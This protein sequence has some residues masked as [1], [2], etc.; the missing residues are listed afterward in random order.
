M[1][2]QTLFDRVVESLEF[3]NGAELAAALGRSK[4]AASWYR[5]N[6]FPKAQR[7]DLLR[8]AQERGRELPPELLVIVE[9][10]PSSANSV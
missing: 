5:H 9:R 4:Q 10:T 2:H 6:G 3:R 7:F 8:L 1:D